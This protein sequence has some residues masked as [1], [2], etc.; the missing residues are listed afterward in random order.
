MKHAA[1][2]YDE[3][4]YQFTDT[5]HHI[6]AII[7]TRTL[8]LGFYK[9]DET[10]IKASRQRI[11]TALSLELGQLICAEQP[12]SDGVRVVGSN[13]RG[14][15]AARFA[16]AIKDTDALVTNEKGVA[17]AVFTADCLPIFLI[18]RE[19]NVIACVHAGWRGTQKAIARKAITAMQERFGTRP[20]N[21]S[22][23]FGPAIRRC[24]YEVGQ[25]FLAYFKRGIYR[26]KEGIRL[27]LIELNYLALREAGVLDENIF[28]SEICT[29]CRNDAFF[30]FRREKEAC[31]RQMA[32]IVMQ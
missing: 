6:K 30:S 17:L 18:D 31:G 16:D 25:E 15:G 9:Q 4:F 3:N 2:R 21:I 28:D 13:E 14:R 10:Q 22:A 1:L 7:T 20:E 12:H 5:P 29:A 19:K 32:L 26:E 27:D 24:C 23:Y 8:D 11:L